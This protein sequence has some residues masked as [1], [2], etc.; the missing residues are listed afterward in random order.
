MSK[1][2]FYITALRE[3]DEQKRD[4]SGDREVRVVFSNDDRFTLP[5]DVPIVSENDEEDDFNDTSPV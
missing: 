4:V 5:H 1:E 3:E 2:W